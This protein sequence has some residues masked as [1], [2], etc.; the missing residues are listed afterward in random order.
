M[1][2]TLGTAATAAGINKST[3]LRSIKSG[4]ISATRTEQGNWSIDP[5]EFHRVYPVRSSQP[6]GNGAVPL[7]AIADETTTLVAS[8]RETIADLRADR[9][10]WR[11][12]AQRLALPDRREHQSWWRWLR[13]G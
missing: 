3:V 9:D 6:N 12:Q 2:Y 8:L 7:D 13:T 5:A 10:A 4:K 1:S 11:E